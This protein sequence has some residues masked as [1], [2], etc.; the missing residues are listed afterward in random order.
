MT[1]DRTASVISLHTQP[2][3]AA[4]GLVA[5]DDEADVVALLGLGDEINRAI[6]YG[7][8]RW[9]LA[10]HRRW[11]G[12]SGAQTVVNFAK[13]EPYWKPLV[14]LWALCALDPEGIAE[15]LGFDP[16][17]VVSVFGEP[18]RPVT[19][20]G[21][22]IAAQYALRRLAAAGLYEI[23]WDDW[24]RATAAMRDARLRT[25]QA[26]GKPLAAI[27]CQQW[28]YRLSTLHRLGEI[29][30][31]ENPFGSAP[32]QNQPAQEVFRPTGSERQQLNAVRPT[33]AV[34]EV[35]GVAAFV[36]DEL[37][38]DILEH[39][40]WWQSKRAAATPPPDTEAARAALCDLYVDIARANDGRVPGRVYNGTVAVPHQVMCGLIGGVE[41]LAPPPKP[42][43]KLADKATPLSKFALTRAERILGQSL[44]PDPTVSPCPLPLRTFPSV[45]HPDVEVPWASRLLWDPELRWWVS[46][47][48][49]AVA[50][51]L[52]ATL[53]LRDLDRDLLAVGCVKE[54]T[55]DRDGEPVRAW[56]LHGWK[57]KKMRVPTKT[58]FAVGE[59]VARAV[60][61]LERLHRLLGVE[62]PEISEL[63]ERGHRRLF[64]SE[65]NIGADSGCTRPGIYLDVR[66]MRWFRGM[67]ERLHSAGVVPSDLSDVPDVD[68]REIRIT[69]MQ[70]YAD[71]TLGQALSAAYG[72]WTTARVMRGYI[73]DVEE[74]I[75]FV[76]DSDDTEAAAIEARANH[77]VTLAA[78][79]TTLS[80]NGLGKL[81]AAVHAHNDVFLDLDLANP[82][83]LT[84]AQLTKLGKTE[85]NLELG[86]YTHCFFDRAHALCGGRGSADF[87]LCRPGACHNSVMTRGQ[88]AAVELRRRTLGRLHPV[89]ARDRSKIDEDLARDLEEFEGLSDA[90]LR[91]IIERETD[92]YLDRAVGPMKRR[93]TS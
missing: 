3:Q 57:Q 4:A 48:V 25:G 7:D 65:L 16:L 87:R 51:Y 84:K 45:R 46:A 13:V 92:R 55:I 50:Y 81:A 14:K 5:P 18:A 2:E 66:Y 30:G 38:E 31:W 28:A 93:T 47:L 78:N 58:T 72:K 49:F 79:E 39:L 34:G 63:P 26:T 40:G 59:R 90:E 9:D 17:S 37:A 64:T 83:P 52:Q 29:A 53:G 21:N 27:T 6:R 42:G 32:W 11:K 43:K 86:P 76:A 75:V 67:A 33:E 20:R 91:S 77:L 73:G 88:R 62:A 70:A 22:V 1:P 15:Q 23:A 82:E 89:L 8:D 80:G 36:I 74:R 69:A 19:V 71:R 10:G 85:R 54:T 68:T 35:L 41:H 12:K 56:V 61:L 24:D 60:G 44:V